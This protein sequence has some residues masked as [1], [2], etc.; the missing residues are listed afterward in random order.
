MNIRAARAAAYAMPCDRQ[1]LEAVTG[2]CP[3]SCKRLVIQMRRELAMNIEWSRA[4]GYV[5]RDWGCLRPGQKE[6]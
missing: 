2:L 1:R 5:I 3:V 4:T 6:K